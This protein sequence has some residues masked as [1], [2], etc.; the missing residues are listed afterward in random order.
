MMVIKKGVLKAWYPATYTA[1]VQIGGSGKAYLEG[2]KVARNLA[3]AE[4]AP[5]RNVAVIFWDRNNAEDAVVV[6][7]Y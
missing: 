6:A 5:G 2:I 3:A 1:N 4:M 7:V